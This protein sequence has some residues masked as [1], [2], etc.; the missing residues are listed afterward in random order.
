MFLA[1]VESEDD[2]GAAAIAETEASARL[3]A[4]VT[5]QGLRAVIERANG[6]DVLRLADSRGRLVLEAREGSHG[7][8]LSV[9][10]GDLVL[11]SERGRVRI[12]AAEGVEI[13]SKVVTITAGR[14]RQ[15]VG[16]LETQAKRIFEKSK[17]T[18][19]EVSGL[20]QLRAEDVRI[21]AKST[22]RALAE[23]LRMKAKEEVKIDGEKIYLG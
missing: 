21:V 20:S 15:A 4:I 12:E 18:Y 19:R 23:R 16:V 1:M 7:V 3:D 8:I 13:E 14:L 6:G 2:S 10:E 11:R 9:A 17:D 5:R 22:L